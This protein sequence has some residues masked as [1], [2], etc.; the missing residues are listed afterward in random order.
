MPLVAL[1]II[2]FLLTGC[3]PANTPENVT[4]KYLT[5][6]SNH[7]YEEAAKYCTPETAQLLSIM[8]SMS[9]GEEPAG[10]KHENIECNVEGDKAQCT[11]NIVGSEEIEVIDLIKVDD[12][13]KVHMEK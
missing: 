13:W 9:E 5:H 7:K 11:Y 1:F 8:A 6:L 2:A 3:E 4:D 10:D 12:E